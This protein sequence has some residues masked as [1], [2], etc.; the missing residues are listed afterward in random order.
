MKNK[1]LRISLVLIALLWFSLTTPI[2]SASRE[3]S[4]VGQRFECM[5]KIVDGERRLIVNPEERPYVEF[6]SNQ[7]CEYLDGGD[8]ST[9]VEQNNRIMIV[10]GGAIPMLA[11]T[12]VSSIRLRLEGYG[13][14]YYSYEE[15]DEF[16]YN[17]TSDDYIS[18]NEQA[19]TLREY[20]A[21]NTSMGKLE[22][23]NRLIPFRNGYACVADEDNNYH[24]IDTSGNI[25]MS[26]DNK[27]ISSY[28]WPIDNGVTLIHADDGIYQM[29]DLQNNVIKEFSASD[30]SRVGAP[31]EGYVCAEKINRTLSGTSY[32]T[33]YYDNFGQEQLAFDNLCMLTNGLSNFSNGRAFL[34]KENEAGSSDDEYILVDTFGNAQILGMDDTAALMAA[35]KGH[36]LHAHEEYNAR[37]TPDSWEIK[38]VHAF[39]KGEKYAAAIISIK[40]SVNETN[41]FGK[42]YSY[43]D[44]VEYLACITLD[45]KVTLICEAY[46][47]SPCINNSIIFSK[48]SSSNSIYNITEDQILD[49]SQIA[50]LHDAKNHKV[51]FID[52]GQFLVSMNSGDFHAVIERNGKVISEPIYNPDFFF[53]NADMLGNSEEPYASDCSL[54]YEINTKPFTRIL[55]SS[56]IAGH[57]KN[58]NS[59][60]PSFEYVDITGTRV[61]GGPYVMGLNFVNGYTLVGSSISESKNYSWSPLTK[62]LYFINTEGEHVDHIELPSSKKTLISQFSPSQ[63][64]RFLSTKLLLS[65]CQIKAPQQKKTKKT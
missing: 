50:S 15:Y 24:Y 40:Y 62:N 36:Y 48:N 51:S 64:S 49:V 45:G 59:N 52:N 10:E 57:V 46:S 53:N 29:V 14:M 27:Y 8:N 20:D 55:S 4:L 54:R 31:S 23:I 30:Y 2:A 38:S 21:K 33:V 60:T 34:K 16:F 13:L 39:E 61:A 43:K 32:S 18:L 26:V 22:R 19:K 58:R 65:R 37:I 41:S 47:C 9:Y 7:K 42:E 44:D 6:L 3:S 12:S 11:F 5:Y 1:W 56:L 25:V 17:V 28:Y 35:I 63:S